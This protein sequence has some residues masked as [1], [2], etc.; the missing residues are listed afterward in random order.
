MY[1]DNRDL[2]VDNLKKKEKYHPQVY[3]CVMAFINQFPQRGLVLDIG[4]RDG[5]AVQLLEYNGYE[6]IGSDLRKEHVEYAKKRGRNVVVDNATN[7]SFEDGWFDYIFSRHCIEHTQEPDRFLSEC[8]RL[9][10]S[11]GKVFLVFPK[12][13]DHEWRSRDKNDH[14]THFPDKDSFR[15]ISPFK[16]IFFGKSKAKGIDSKNEY[17]FIGEK[18]GL[19][20]GS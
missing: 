6:A 9:L 10:K 1:G 18:N 12:E 15:K 17:L 3:G 16:E 4:S 8:H 11:S 19:Q 7:S 13:S 5:Y 14:L 20:P 2:P